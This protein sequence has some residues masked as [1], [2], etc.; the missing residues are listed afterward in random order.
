LKLPLL[1]YFDVEALQAL[2]SGPFSYRYATARRGEELR[3]DYIQ[4]ATRL[5]P[6]GGWGWTLAT[7]YSEAG[8]AFGEEI[9]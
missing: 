9:D 2:A 1:N 7:D 4:P 3:T 5:G 8:E 6:G